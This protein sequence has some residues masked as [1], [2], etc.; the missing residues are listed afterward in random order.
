MIAQL[1]ALTA[2]LCIGLALA[3]YGILRWQQYRAGEIL[4][5]RAVLRRLERSTPRST[6]DVAFGLLVRLDD[7]DDEGRVHWRGHRT[8]VGRPVG[9][10]PRH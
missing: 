7:E 4:S 9:A 3:A 10:P 6:A 1:I 2:L 8:M 5:R